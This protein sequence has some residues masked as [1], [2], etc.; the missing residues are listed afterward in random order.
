[1]IR[2]EQLVLAFIDEATDESLEVPFYRE[3][4]H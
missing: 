1:M 4:A 3:F 2:A